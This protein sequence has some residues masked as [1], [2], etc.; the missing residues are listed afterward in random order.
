MALVFVVA[1][2]AD[3]PR[4]EP[5]LQVLRAQ[6]HRLWMVGPDMDWRYGAA[7]SLHEFKAAVVFLSRAALVGAPRLPLGSWTLL[8]H[9]PNA[10]LVELLQGA[11]D[12]P[13]VAGVR[14][15][16]PLAVRSALAAALAQSE[17]GWTLYEAVAAMAGAKLIGAVIDSTLS[18]H[19]LPAAIQPL[20]LID[21]PLAADREPM[22]GRGMGSG[23]RAKGEAA[24]LRAVRHRLGQSAEALSL[25]AALGESARHRGRG[26][27]AAA[28]AAVFGFL[29]GGLAALGLG[30]VFGGGENGVEQTVEARLTPIENEITALENRLYEESARAR[31]AEEVEARQGALL[32]AL[33][34]NIRDPAIC[35]QGERLAPLRL[36]ASSDLVE[37]DAPGPGGT[38]PFASGDGIWSIARKAYGPNPGGVSNLIF[39]ANL[40][41][42]C[43]D[44]GPDV[45]RTKKLRIPRLNEVLNGLGPAA[46]A[47]PRTVV[48]QGSAAG[49]P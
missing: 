42:F 47:G 6:G 18:P 16:S 1:A 15:P 10:D 5:T 28:L 37:R 41:R 45:I 27:N 36:E 35:Q 32:F 9:L 24:L 21:L 40:E 31:L 17:K 22:G 20:Q 25:G 49:S 19:E 39:L 7:Q 13:A 46:V 29:G 33:T 38:A 44:G 8:P 12:R 30:G 3:R 4:I 23:T 11:P 26:L 2:E 34:A 14:P 48:D 43:A